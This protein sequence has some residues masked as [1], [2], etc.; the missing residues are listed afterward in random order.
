MNC[1]YHQDRTGNGQCVCGKV[2][3]A[4]CMQVTNNT[5]L[6]SECALKHVAE[7]RST[8]IK[9]LVFSVIA[10]GIGLGLGGLRIGYMF[11]SIFWGR[12]FL[13][14]LFGR[15]L[16]GWLFSVDVFLWIKVVQ[17]VI[18]MDVGIFTAPI[19]VGLSIYRVIQLNKQTAAIKQLQ[20]NL[21]A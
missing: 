8:L 21:L 4:D 16:G 11:F 9:T 15:A 5:G 18:Y 19:A 7:Y 17:Y 10:G 20:T 3:C 14:S 2:L 6:C 12:Q 1:F 13:N